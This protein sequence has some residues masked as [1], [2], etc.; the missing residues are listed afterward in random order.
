MNSFLHTIGDLL[1]KFY[2]EIVAG[3][4][5]VIL[6]MPLD[7]Y[8]YTTFTG[9]PSYPHLGGKFWLFFTSYTIFFLLSAIFVPIIRRKNMQF[10]LKKLA[11]QH[12]I[13]D[14]QKKKLE[15]ILKNANSYQP[16]WTKNGLC[17]F[18]LDNFFSISVIF[19]YFGIEGLIA[20]FLNNE[21]KVVSI[22]FIGL[23]FIFMWFESLLDAYITSTLKHQSKIK[24]TNKQYSVHKKLLSQIIE[25]I[26]GGSPS[27]DFGDFII[28]ETYDDIVEITQ[29]LDTNYNKY[30]QNRNLQ[31]IRIKNAIKNI[32]H[33]TNPHQSHHKNKVDENKQSLQANGK[34]ASNVSIDTIK[35]NKNKTTAQDT[36]SPNNHQQMRQNSQQQLKQNYSNIQSVATQVK[37]A[38][39]ISIQQP[40]TKTTS[41]SICKT[42]NTVNDNNKKTEKIVQIKL[43]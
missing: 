26:G 25:D 35:Q 23:F 16:L 40:T 14:L 22:I 34:L 21:T 5:A 33:M 28:N 11:N 8:L 24:K 39:K 43:S 29:L 31:N 27:D 20:N 17:T 2:L 3:I 37:T 41:Q 10:T 15:N 7:N 32:N 6:T 19:A 13:T 38:N 30:H 36:K 12:K 18:L 9:V 4:W 1:V 42:T